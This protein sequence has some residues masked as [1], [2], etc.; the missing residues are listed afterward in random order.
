M[1]TP[2]Y[3]FA[4][5]YAESEPSRM[6]MPAHKGQLFLGCEPF[7]ITEI[8]GADELFS[9][10]GIIAESEKNASEIFG[11]PTFY[12]AEGSS[13]CIRTMLYLAVQYAVFYGKAP[14]IAAF[15]NAHR[16]FMTAAV[17]LDFQPVWVD[18]RA[19]DGLLS[20]YIDIRV[21]EDFFRNTYPKPAALYVTSPDYLGNIADIRSI[22][23]ICRR[24]DV[25]LLVDNAHGAYLHFLE[26]SQHPVA[27]G[28]DICCDSAHKTLPVLTGGA[29]IHFSPKYEEFFVSRVKTAMSLFASTSPS[30]LILESLDICNSVLSENY[31]DKLGNTVKKLESVRDKLS[32]IG[33]KFC[34]NEPMKLTIYAKKYGYYGTEIADILNKNGIIHEFADKDHVVLMLSY[35]NTF[36]EIDRLYDILSDIPKK[37][38]I[39]EIQPCTGNTHFALSPRQAV[40]SANE[41]L[42]VS[43]CEGRICAEI[44]YSCPP[45]VP[46]VFCGELI[47]AKAVRCFE[48]YGITHVLVVK[49]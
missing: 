11:C 46:I 24:Y 8:G 23:E 39:K 42:P 27:L 20:Q 2:I 47:T 18:G 34:G 4:K 1:N 41:S 25:L 6:H 19:D 31:A 35:L 10:E 40:F 26:P 14:V 49:K 30:Y 13:L 28:A 44:A 16:S 15:R 9:P 38:E 32:E 48:Y 3:D 12:S 7:D 33:W 21:L 43:E 36:H 17:L 29:Y 45:A 5:K 37:P 22:A